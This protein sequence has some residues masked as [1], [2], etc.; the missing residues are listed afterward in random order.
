MIGKRYSYRGVL[1]LG[2]DLLR[3][4]WTD[5]NLA[6]NRQIV[7]CSQVFADAHG[8][9]ADQRLDGCPYVG[10][11]TPAHLSATADLVDVVIGWKKL[12]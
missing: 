4:L 12:V 3:G 11:T 1:S 9:M 10:A 5:N 7:I 2:W 6:A 8:E